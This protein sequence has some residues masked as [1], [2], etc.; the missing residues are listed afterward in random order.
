MKNEQRERDKQGGQILMMGLSGES[1]RR[2]R[3][4]QLDQSVIRFDMCPPS[5][6]HGLG[7]GR[8]GSSRA[9]RPRGRS[10]RAHTCVPVHSR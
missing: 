2:R 4:R 3:R 7:G 8:L 10:T 6:H 1:R 5:Q 9:S